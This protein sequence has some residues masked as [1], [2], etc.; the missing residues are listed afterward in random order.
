MTRLYAA[1]TIE[2]GNFP[3]VHLFG[4]TFDITVII[5][6]LVAAAIIIVIFALVNRKATSGVPNKLQLIV[7]MIAVDLVGDLAES[8]I[9]EKG[10][11][12]VPLGVTIFMFILVSN[13]LNFIPTAMHPGSSFDIFPAPTGNINLPLAMALVVIPW[14]HYESVRA[15]G[16]GG[17]A[18]HYF[19]PSWLMSPIN[20][21][22]EITKP[23][24]LTLRLFG[25]VFAG[26]VMIT[27]MTVLLPIYVLPFGEVIWK[28]F[29][30]LLLGSIQAYIFMLL[31]ILYFGMAMSH[32]ENK[33]TN[34]PALAGTH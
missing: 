23:V 8:A 6:S 21:I 31:T 26:T 4:L 5:S 13:W 34:E 33:A 11:K 30:D 9:G 14:V 15:R 12:F 24:T 25:N 2:V 17:Y 1:K 18:G 27:L 3:T 22:E 19:K 28:P 16:F 20:I 10:K 29:D 32:D 7:E